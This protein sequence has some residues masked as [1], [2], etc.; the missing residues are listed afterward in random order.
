MTQESK[1]DGACQAERH[2]YPKP[3]GGNG[4]QTKQTAMGM[5]K[6][7][8][9]NGR[10]DG[11]MNIGR[12]DW[13]L[14]YG[15]GT[16]EVG[17]WNWCGLY[18]RKPTAEE[19]KQAVRDAIDAETKDKIVNRFE[20]DGTRV[21][22]SDEKQRNFASIESNAD[23]TFPLTLKLNEETDGTPVYRTFAAREDFA[24]FSKA[25]SSHILEAIQEGWREKDSVDWSVF[26]I[27]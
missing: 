25:A 26:G 8:G 20:Y 12:Q 11:L 16:D 23:I 3:L 27:E 22:L 1:G 6:R 7:Y 10:A 5:M 24:A 15:Y 13:A 21:Y 19:V 17:A 14:T 4:E 18:A 9:A 2:A